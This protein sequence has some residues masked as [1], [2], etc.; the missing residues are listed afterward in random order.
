VIS[1]KLNHINCKACIFVEALIAGYGTGRAIITGGSI[2]I[3]AWNSTDMYGTTMK[4]SFVYDS[5]DIPT[6]PGIEM[7]DKTKIAELFNRSVHVFDVVINKSIPVSE[8]IDKEL[9]IT[10]ILNESLTVGEV[11]NTTYINDIIK[12]ENKSTLKQIMGMSESLRIVLDGTVTLMNVLD[13]NLPIGYVID[14]NLPIGQVLNTS[15]KAEIPLNDKIFFHEFID[16]SITLDAIIENTVVIKEA[17]DYIQLF[18]E[19]VE[20]ENIFNGDSIFFLLRELYKSGRALNDSITVF[21]SSV[22]T[23]ATSANNLNISFLNDKN[24]SKETPQLLQYLEDISKQLDTIKDKVSEMEE[25]AAYLHFD[26]RTFNELH[27]EIGKVDILTIKTFECVSIIT[28]LLEQMVD[29]VSEKPTLSG[30]IVDFNR[31]FGMSSSLYSLLKIKYEKWLDDSF[32]LIFSIRKESDRDIQILELIAT[33]IKLGDLLNSSIYLKD[34]LHSSV[35]LQEL[36]MAGNKVWTS[37]D[38]KLQISDIINDHGNSV[39]L[40]DILVQ[41]DNDKSRVLQPDYILPVVINDLEHT[42]VRAFVS[43]PELIQFTTY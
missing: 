14:N 36:E 35:T 37:L 32:A 3:Y 29:L 12:C 34:V 11:I 2:E 1:D 16:T 8:L 26:N 15:L 13:T 6:V 7:D 10:R 27:T 30:D 25:S 4:K 31:T 39:Y 41:S 33:H 23:V 40:V 28:G 20:L 43:Y 42:L 21:K 38:K 17:F 9:T 5:V 22:Y 24:K 19:S 18:N